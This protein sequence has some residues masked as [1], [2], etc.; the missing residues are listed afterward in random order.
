[1]PA[2]LMAQAWEAFNHAR[3]VLAD[4]CAVDASGSN[5]RRAVREV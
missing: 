5:A 2:E 3:K 1:V 4:T